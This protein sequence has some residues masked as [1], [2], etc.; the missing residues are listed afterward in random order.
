MNGS[1]M[2]VL[3]QIPLFDVFTS[4]EKELLAGQFQPATYA[5]GQTIVDRDVS[6]DSFYILVTGQARK[7]GISAAGKETNLGLLK[8]GEH[9][10]EHSLLDDKTVPPYI[11]RA[12]TDLEVL[13]ISRRQFKEMAADHPAI[14]KYVQDF[15]ASDV[16]RSFLKNNT[17]LTHVDHA[18]LRS[19]LDRLEVRTYAPEECLVRE[20]DAGD[21]F[22]ILKNGSALVEKGEEAAVVNRLYPGDFFGELALL[23]GQPRQA[24]IRAAEPVT[25]FRLSKTAFDELIQTYPVI[26]ESI[27]RISA[28]YTAQAMV[29]VKAPEEAEE[30]GEAALS[31]AARPTDASE[32]AA[33]LAGPSWRTWGR[34]RKYPALLQQNEMDCGPTCLT[35]LARYYGLNASVNRMRERCNVGAEGTSMLG[36]IETL[37]S[38]GFEAQGLKTTSALLNELKTPFIAHWNGNHY[39][40]VYE[41]GESGVVVADPAVGCLDTLPLAAFG[42]HWTGY[43]ITLQPA[44]PLE[45]LDDQEQLWKR[46]LGYFRPY[47]KLLGS[48]LGLSITIELVFLVFPV[49]TQQIFDRVLDTKDW[50]LLRMIMAAMLALI[51]FNI[52]GIAVR[53][54]LIGR[55]AYLI[56]HA[57]L[58][59]FYRHL[60]RLPYFYFTKRTSGDIL[61]RVQENEKIRRLLTD[62][63]IE[64]LLDFL[65]LL[66]YGGLMVYYHPGLAL[67]SF[68]FMPLYITLYAYLLPKIRRNLRK[69]LIAEGESQTQ[70]VEAVQ[71]IASVKGLA[72]EQTVRSKLMLKLRSLLALRLE[73]NKLDAAAKAAAVGLRSLSKVS[74][75]YFGSRYVLEGALSVGELVAYTV[76]FTS[77]MFALEMISQRSSELSE[78]RISMERLNDVYESTPEHPDPDKMRMLPAIQGHIRFDHISFQYYRGGKMI[79]QNLD[80]ELKPGQT[81]ALIGRSGSGKSTIANLLLKLLEPSAGMIYIDGYPLHEV[82]AASIRKQ[83]GVVQQD[84]MLFRGTVRENIAL[85][86]DP[87]AFEAIERAAQLAGAHEFIQALPLGY[88]TIIGEGGMR[89]SGGQRQRIVIARALVNNPRILIFDEATSALDTESERIIQQNMDEMLQGRTTLIIAHRLSTIRHA[90]LIVVLDQGAVVESGTHEQ[91]FQ[92]KG[93]YHHLL[94]QQSL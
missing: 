32:P 55:L 3:H 51:G 39:I 15:V 19:L 48:A 91:L 18:A 13:R 29:M 17:V 30:T 23:T 94:Q 6:P 63:A 83:I 22:Y 27:R 60:F 24:T 57:M 2:Q 85:S 28:H 93:L 16:I 64:L 88:D 8:P 84:T 53:Q 9:F 61:T 79:L 86:G 67:V 80:L 73:G 26:L 78:A 37:E 66:V 72:M 81:V 43:V 68:A 11:I 41:I 33:S 74:L 47:K 45:P 42:S 21:A 25:A 54:L 69:Q 50:S 71:A 52:A 62:H 12:S 5:M 90:D 89:L 58:E 49:M 4:E 44:G 7:I 75:L 56:D 35:M 77:F 65:T 82:H 31:D 87:A 10:G 92:R 46:Y 70:I 36:L 1:R 59:Q 34:R 14:Q 38:I 76:L 20:G 40:V